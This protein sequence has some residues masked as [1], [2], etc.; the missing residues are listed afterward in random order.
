VRASDTSGLDIT[1]TVARALTDPARVSTLLEG[2]SFPAAL[3]S[4]SELRFTWTNRVF[5]DLLDDVRPQWDLLGMPVRGFLSDS[6][7]AARFID[8]AY[9][10]QP[11]TVPAY[12]FRASWGEVSYWQLSY[13]PVPGRI[14]HPYDVLLLAVDVSTVMAEQ[15]EAEEHAADLRR[16]LDLIDVTVLS[17]LDAEDILQRVLVEA[18]EALGAD[19]GWIA[20]REGGGWVFRNVHGWPAEMAGLRFAEDDLSLPG[21]VARGDRA[22]AVSQSDAT[23]REHFELMV[24]HDIGAFALVPV[25]NRGEV[26]DVMGF[27][28]DADL[29]F[30]DAHREL[31]RKLE[32]SLSLALENAR[33]FDAERRLTR[34]LRGAFFSAPAAVPGFEMGHLYHSAFGTS[35]VGGDFYDV[36]SLPGGR[37][38]VLIGDVAG[39]GTDAAGLTALVKSAMR[40]EALRLPSPESVMDRA[41]E[42]VLHGAASHEFASAFFGLVDGVSGHM[43]YSMAGH[44][45]PVLLRAGAEPVLLQADGCVLG[46]SGAMRYENHGTTLDIGDLLVLYTDGLTEARSASGVPFGT[47]RLLEAISSSAAEPAERVPESLF[48]AAFGHAEGRLAD[49]IAIVALR[50]REVAGD[51]TQGRLELEAAVA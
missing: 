18:T 3:W 10:G 25:K 11:T 47:E 45:P 33:Q 27:C 48:L 7:S 14:G 23:K 20:E 44:P 24:K 37:V 51:P 29:A 5:R 41:N 31:L 38:G 4:G 43:A 32:L 36:M 28:W 8:V 17:S 16:A 50:R 2:A 12:E 42:I 26:V 13:L 35:S 22:L 1:A 9:T 21:L 46:A 39:H 49:D 40:A 15:R 34:M 19:W 6:H 30:G